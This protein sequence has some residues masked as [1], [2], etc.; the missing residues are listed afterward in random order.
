[1]DFKLV[2]LQAQLKN[3]CGNVSEFFRTP[4]QAITLNLRYNCIIK[5]SRKKKRGRP[6]GGGGGEGRVT[7]EKK[8]KRKKDKKKNLGRAKGGGGGGKG[9]ATKEKIE[10]EN[11]TITKSLGFN[12]IKTSST[13]YFLDL[14]EVFFKVLVALTLR[15][16]F[17]G[18]LKYQC[19]SVCVNKD[20]SGVV[21]FN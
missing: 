16:F 7:K 21:T 18:F 11:N 15:I 9:P 19:L 13:K 5:G 10:N 4:F 14:Y 1:M 12:L 3:L 2:I 6:N 8:K 17:C 20:R